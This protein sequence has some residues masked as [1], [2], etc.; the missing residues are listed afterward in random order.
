MCG[1]IGHCNSIDCITNMFHL[2]IGHSEYLVA[3]YFLSDRTFTTFPL[4]TNMINTFIKLSIKPSIYVFDWT[5][6]DGG[7]SE[8]INVLYRIF[9]QVLPWFMFS[10]YAL[11]QKQRWCCFACKRNVPPWQKAVLQWLLPTVQSTR[12]LGKKY[13][14]LY[15]LSFSLSSQD[16][17]QDIVNIVNIVIIFKILNIVQCPSPSRRA[18]I[19][20]FFYICT[21]FFRYLFIDC[22]KSAIIFLAKTPAGMPERG[23]RG[24]ISPFSFHYSFSF[25]V[26]LPNKWYF[27]P[28]V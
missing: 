13:L 25:S 21:T 4:L 8:V 23:K 5:K 10:G 2:M 6:L 15:L 12:W 14:L 18:C 19:V 7:P 11:W 20:S 9:Y 1:S 3:T 16:G 17:V 24:H 28:K 22:L 26:F 27:W